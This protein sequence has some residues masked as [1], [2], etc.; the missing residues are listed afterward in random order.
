M[1]AEWMMHGEYQAGEPCSISYFHHLSARAR[2]G[3]RSQGP[4]LEQ[5]I[6]DAKQR[7]NDPILYD[8]KSIRSSIESYRNISEGK[9][10]GATKISEIGKEIEQNFFLRQKHNA[11]KVS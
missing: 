3:N 4:Y 5:D 11:K 1:A 6:R 10:I 8:Q 7:L 2:C 9:Y